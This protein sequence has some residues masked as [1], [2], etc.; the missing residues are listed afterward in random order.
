MN[1]IHKVWV[2]ECEDRSELTA[3]FAYQEDAK[4]FAKKES[5]RWG[6]AVVSRHFPGWFQQF[7][8]IEGKLIKK[9]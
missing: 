2:T 3:E 5:H 7:V 9:K 4:D 6:Q 1:R 8:Y